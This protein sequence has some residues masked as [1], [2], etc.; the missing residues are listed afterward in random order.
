MRRRQLLEAALASGSLGLLEGCSQ[1]PSAAAPTQPAGSRPPAIQPEVRALLELGLDAARSAGA[2][3]A[4]IRIGDYRMQAL[5]TREARV[6]SLADDLSSGFGVRVIAQGT[7]GFAASSQ[8]TREAVVRVARQAVAMARTNSALQRE[9]VQLAPAP[10]QVGS[11]RTPLRRDAFTVSLE[12]KLERLFSLN[13]LAQRQTGVSFVDS[14][15]S[16]VREHKYFASSEGS[17]IEQT[18]DRLHPAFSITCVDQKRGE[19]V[20]GVDDGDDEGRGAI[21]IDC[22]EID[23]RLHE[24]AARVERV[25]ARRIHQ[26][27]PGAER[28]N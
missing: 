27:R 26:W 11:Y 21:G 23:A 16:F 13:A 18:L 22:V 19:L 17:L 9:P 12:E 7:W 3:Y 5:R 6:V 1:P 8:L 15:M 28:Q 24:R 14:R 20:V 4:D 2:S 25:L 10:P